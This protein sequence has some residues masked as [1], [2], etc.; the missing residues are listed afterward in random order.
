M[1]LPH[2]GVQLFAA[3]VAFP[4]P[5]F[6]IPKGYMLLSLGVPSMADCHP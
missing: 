2:P 3:F 4:V 1:S 6:W 5:P